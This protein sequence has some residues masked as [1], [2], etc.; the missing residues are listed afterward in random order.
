MIRKNSRTF[1]VKRRD[2]LWQ[3]GS[4]KWSHALKGL[5]CYTLVEKSWVVTLRWKL[6][7]IQDLALLINVGTRSLG[8]HLKRMCQS[9]VLKVLDA[10][11][12]EYKTSKLSANISINICYMHMLYLLVIPT[13]KE[14]GSDNEAEILP[15]LPQVSIYPL[16]RRDMSDGNCRI[17]QKSPYCFLWQTVQWLMGHTSSVGVPSESILR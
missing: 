17:Q 16:I 8:S 7:K 1:M 12:I 10:I 2:I 5:S 4:Q 9:Q 14:S 13:S 11:G 6:H 15:V 3:V